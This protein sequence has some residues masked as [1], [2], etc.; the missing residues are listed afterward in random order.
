MKVRIIMKNKKLLSLLLSLLL[1]S[2]SAQSSPEEA[3]TTP[4]ST[5]PDSPETS[6]SA[7]VEAPTGEEIDYTDLSNW[8]Y[9][10]EEKTPDTLVDCF[11]VAPTVYSAAQ[12]EPLN[13]AMDNQVVLGDFLG[14]SNME[15]GIY[16]EVCRMYAPYYPQIALEAYLFE[17][18][19]REAYLEIAYQG[20]REAFL[21]YMNEENG[22]R[23]LI[24]AGFSQGA[25]MCL[26][27][28][29]EF[30]GLADG[31][32]VACYAIGWGITQEELDQYPHLKMAEAANDLGGIITFNTEA[33]GIETSLTVP[34]TTLAINPLNWTT[35]SDYAPPEL[36]LG[37]CFTDYDANI[38]M[39]LPALT[40]AYLDPNRG[41]LIV[42]DH[43]TPAEYPPVL[44]IFED[45]VYHLYDYLFFYRN[46]QENVGTRVEE[47][48]LTYGLK[49]QV[50]GGVT[51][52][53][54]G[55]YS[56]FTH[57]ELQ[58]GVGNLIET[59]EEG[60]AVR[61]VV[62]DAP[63]DGSPEFDGLAELTPE[64]ILLTPELPFTLEGNP[65]VG[66]AIDFT[67]PDSPVSITVIFQ[68]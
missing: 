56:E 17:G 27:L 58:D 62:Y 9:W 47:Y 23:P 67:Y 5:T 3:G 63:T 35:T 60:E 29:K 26:R 42:D 41:T 2:C 8:A 51:V 19:E 18:E 20:V 11:F 1:V 14:A 64:D 65:S 24:L 53:F 25:D 39:E 49:P 10:G 43:I 46:L 37:A 66:Y 44:E 61:V 45:G 12:G 22:D 36:N 13:L 6:A 34:Q 55:A 52:D 57:Y 48:A 21:H 68:G 15:R 54:G 33:E 16:D 7:S 4:D 28:L 50:P 32:L 30:N 31:K 38:T 40:G 59:A